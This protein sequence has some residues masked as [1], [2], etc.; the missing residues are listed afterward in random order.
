MAKT[1]KEIAN[2]YI[3]DEAFNLSTDEQVL[4][5]KGF[6]DGANTVLNEIEECLPSTSSFNPN[7][8][9]DFITSRIRELKGE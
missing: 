2:K 4:C 9:I 1:I 6:E 7:E 5:F 8:V 3:V